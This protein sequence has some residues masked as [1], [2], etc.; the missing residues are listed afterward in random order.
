MRNYLAAA[1][2]AIGLAMSSIDCSAGPCSSDIA[3]MQ[4]RLN[5]RLEEKAAAGPT[6]P[7]SQNA[8]RHR[9]PTPRSLAEAERSLG[10]LPPEKGGIVG[11][12]MAR[13]RAADAAGDREACERALDEIRQA[14]WP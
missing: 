14:I 4:A 8:L 9:Q 3:A 11:A 12:A 10:E 5:A 2:A 1:A 13:A 7:E 6:A